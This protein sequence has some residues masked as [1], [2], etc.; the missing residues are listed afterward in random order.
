MKFISCSF[1]ST[2]ENIENVAWKV[3]E[4][5]VSCIHEG[6]MKQIHILTSKQTVESILDISFSFP[7][8][9]DLDLNF[10]TLLPVQFQMDFPKQ[11]CHSQK[12]RGG[13]QNQFKKEKE[14]FYC[15]MLTTFLVISSSGLLPSESC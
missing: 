15:L 8:T 14:I 3:M 5:L 10:S 9:Q 6:D 12:D 11:M 1:A 2:E 13:L 7:C 4:F